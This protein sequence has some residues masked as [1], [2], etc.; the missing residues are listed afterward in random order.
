MT[1]GDK[2]KFENLLSVFSDNFRV[3]RLYAD[4]LNIFPEIITKDMIDSIKENGVDEIYAI[5]A[6]L[7][8]IFALDTENKED[9][10]RLFRSYILP[11]IRILDAKKYTENPYYKSVK[12]PNIKLD[13]WEF[14]NEAY[15][16]YRAVICHDMMLGSD[17]SEIPPLGFFT[18]RFEFPAV[19]EDGNEWMTLTPVDLDTSEYAI[20]RA[21]GKVVTFGLGLGY[22]AYMASEK[23]EVK[24][25]TVVEKSEKVIELFKKYVFPSFNHPEKIRIVISDAFEY[26][27]KAMPKE[28]F[29]FAFVDTWR[30]ASDG[31]PMYEKMKRLEHLSKGTEFTYWIENFLISNI[32]ARKLVEIRE[33]YDLGNLDM[34]YSD[35]VKELTTIP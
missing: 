18:E 7:A 24:S 6:L 4:Y 12:L 33:K 31:A 2:T 9:D 13:N 30:D 28:N 20:E 11:S 16:P 23:D 32:R 1:Y 17:F 21:F 8:E 25:V 27:E 35:I 10:K 5:S 34:S 22:F 3:T 14:K 26:A 15:E 29:D 19:L